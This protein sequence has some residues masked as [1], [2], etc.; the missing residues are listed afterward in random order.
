MVSTVFTKVSPSGGE[1]EGGGGGSLSG[2]HRSRPIRPVLRSAF[3]SVACALLFGLPAFGQSDPADTGETAQA[4]SDAPRIVVL[5]FRVHSAKQ[6]DF[7]G[8][9]LANLVRER[10]EADDQVVVVDPEKIDA[11]L[12]DAGG[13]LNTDEALRELAAKLDADFVVAGSVTELAG[14]YSL[15]MRLTPA[16][17]RLTK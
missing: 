15:D 13:E 10:L 8:N 1:P 9:S 11:A 5:P 7:L 12:A 17:L 14:S 2:E 6:I 16:L 3:A 4:E